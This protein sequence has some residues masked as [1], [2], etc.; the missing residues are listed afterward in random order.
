MYGKA[1]ANRGASIFPHGIVESCSR[2]A[3]LL[4]GFIVDHSQGDGGCALYRAAAYGGF[5]KAEADD[6]AASLVAEGF[7]DLEWIKVA[8]A[9]FPNGNCI[10]ESVCAVRPRSA[11]EL[12]ERLPQAAWSAL[13]TAVFERDDYTC[14]YC[15]Q[16]GG[17]LECD[18]V[19]AIAKGGTNEEG[20]LVTACAACNKSK[21]D[22]MLEEWR[23]QMV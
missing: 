19:I 8:V 22:K 4:Y 17:A 20:N 3:V 23:H 7:I 5:P 10:M 15:K 9:R 16:R 12:Q 21:R 13:R 11:P 6:L 2:D 1:I 14:A 18:H